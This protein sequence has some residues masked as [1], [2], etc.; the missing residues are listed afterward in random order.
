M[1]GV[2]D[3]DKDT[4]VTLH[5]LHVPCDTAIHGQSRCGAAAT[6][7]ALTT[8]TESYGIERRTQTMTTLTKNE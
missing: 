1:A 5:R 3:R 6:A 2:Q 4:D 7:L 8:T